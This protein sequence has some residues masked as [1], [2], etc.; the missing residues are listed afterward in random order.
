MKF[1]IRLTP[2]KRG[3]PGR[4]VIQINKGEGGVGRNVGLWYAVTPARVGVP[5]LKAAHYLERGFFTFVS[6]V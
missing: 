3:V 6:Q 2:G 1:S 4:E 5:F